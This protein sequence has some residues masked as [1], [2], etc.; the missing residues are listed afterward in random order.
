MDEPIEDNFPAHVNCF[1]NQKADLILQLFRQS[2]SLSRAQQKI[3]LFEQLLS[4]L[5]PLGPHFMYKTDIIF[6][7]E[8]YF[9]SSMF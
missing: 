6:E 7:T 1:I 4:D 5:S 8:D 3:I 9:F 2:S